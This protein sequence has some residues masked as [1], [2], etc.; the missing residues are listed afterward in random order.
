MKQSYLVLPLTLLLLGGCSGTEPEDIAKVAYD[1]EKAY[2]DSDYK[3]QQKLVYEN[4]SYEVDKTA[5]QKDSGL[6]YEDIQYEI[7]PSNESDQYYVMTTFRNPNGENTVEDQLL[8][9]E[10][11]DE[12]RIDVD[13]SMKIDREEIR[14]KYE[15]EKCI[16][17]KD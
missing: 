12:W 17:C 6:K 1:W 10:K 11:G 9:R 13:Q 15:L 7:Y 4:G 5:K 2:F 8:I 16:H 14:D 3:Q